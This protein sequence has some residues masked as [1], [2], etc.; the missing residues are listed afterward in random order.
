MTHYLFIESRDPFES[1]DTQFM[2]ETAAALK[3]RG[4][5]VT[6][7]LVQNAVLAAREKAQASY[8]DRLSEAG[9]SLLADD[10][11]LSERGIQTVEL[12]ASVR[13]SDIETLVD[14]LAQENTKAIWH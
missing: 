4:N 3:Q 1:R 7:F 9:V 14:S 2:E 13:P 5:T 11:S 8:I 6:V 10:F 12:H